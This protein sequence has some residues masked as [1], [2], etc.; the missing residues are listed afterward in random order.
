MRDAYRAFVNDYSA[1]WTAMFQRL[2][3]E[4]NLPTVVH[5]TAGKDRTGFASALVLLALGVSEETVF[6]DYLST[7]Y[8]QQDFFRFVL[9][10]IP[11]YSFFRTDPQDMLPL[12]EARRE[13]LQV[14]LDEMAARYG[15]VDAYLE[16]ALGV[17]AEMRAKLE[18]HF[19]E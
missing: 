14:A 8:Y 13:Y 4:E 17:D 1:E 7:N 11:L 10:W 16:Q 5:C 6:E 15:S 9:R 12:I 2:V 18:H 19:L 3:R